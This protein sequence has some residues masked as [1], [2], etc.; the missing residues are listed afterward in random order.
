M[1]MSISKTAVPKI[2]CVGNFGTAL[3]EESERE[4]KRI[5]LTS[6]IAILLAAISF[7]LIKTVWA[8]A[9]SGTLENMADECRGNLTSVILDMFFGD[10][11]TTFLQSMLDAGSVIV[12]VLKGVGMGIVLVIIYM[13]IIQAVQRGQDC[14]DMWLKLFIKIAVSVLVIV[15][16]DDILSAIDQLGTYIGTLIQ[17][18]IANP[19]DTDAITR[20]QLIEA[21]CGDS[22]PG[23]I[24]TLGG[25]FQLFLP[26]VMQKLVVLAA[27]IA[28]Y[29]ILIEIAIRRAFVPIAVAEIAGE[30][31]RSPGIR[32]L[33]RYLALYIRIAI[34]VVIAYAGGQ[35]FACAAV[36]GTAWLW[37]ALAIN[38]ACVTLMGMTGNFA[39][40]IVGA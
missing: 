30:G 4:K 10:N 24:K 28:S 19:D 27:K 6:F 21:I 5:V 29:S 11:G 22:S 7:L 34:M 31:M 8:N 15:Y 9:L 20:D 39:N 16:I 2:P 14:M 25:I 32:Y 3:V 33:K 26:W 36:D 1:Q 13:E 23:L 17:E 38:Y 37:D 18:A 12:S 35:L 40:D